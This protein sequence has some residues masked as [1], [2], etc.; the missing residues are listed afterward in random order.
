MCWA[1]TTAEQ[2]T[3][4]LATQRVTVP[5]VDGSPTRAALVYTPITQ[6]AMV[7]ML[8][9]FH[10]IAGTQDVPFCGPR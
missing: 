4:Q 1:G 5:G 2:A 8:R 10:G 9:T 3:I 7:P 6:A